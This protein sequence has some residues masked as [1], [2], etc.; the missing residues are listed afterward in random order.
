[1]DR[2]TSKW[3]PDVKPGHNVKVGSS[4]FKGMRA[5]PEPSKNLLEAEEDGDKTEKD[6]DGDK[7]KEPS[8]EGVKLRPT[9]KPPWQPD[10]TPP[11]LKERLVFRQQTLPDT[12]VQIQPDFYREL[13]AKAVKRWSSPFHVHSMTHQTRVLHREKSLRT[14]DLWQHGAEIVAKACLVVPG[15][16]SIRTACKAVLR[17]QKASSD[18]S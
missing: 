9:P 12:P 14:V 10:P 2:G 16:K 4:V 7:S 18:V 1:M 6:L 17:A 13:R 11:W 5:E 15:P 8:S 3:W